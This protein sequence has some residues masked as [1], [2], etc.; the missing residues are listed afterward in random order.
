MKGQGLQHLGI[1]TNDSSLTGRVPGC[2]CGWAPHPLWPH[3][4]PSRGPTCGE[5]SRL[6]GALATSV[7]TRGRERSSL[8]PLPSAQPLLFKSLILTIYQ[9]ADCLKRKPIS[10]S[11]WST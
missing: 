5:E 7:P 4:D 3:E 6:V 8:H 9:E 10:Q 1:K 2:P 11:F